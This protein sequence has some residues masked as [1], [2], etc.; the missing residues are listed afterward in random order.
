MYNQLSH[1]ISS[2]ELNTGDR[3]LRDRPEAPLSLLH[4]ELRKLQKNLKRT[5]TLREVP[6]PHYSIEDSHAVV[7]NII[8]VLELLAHSTR[9]KGAPLSFTPSRVEIQ[10]LVLIG[11]FTLQHNPSSRFKFDFR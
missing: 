3:W 8:R 1:W 11:W 6:I 9:T 7:S 2:I 10:L 4:T 5:G